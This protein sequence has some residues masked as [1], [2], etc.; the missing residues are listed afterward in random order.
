MK[1]NNLFLL[2]FFLLNFSALA[3]SIKFKWEK[4]DGAILYE[5]EIYP[6]PELTNRL[7]IEQLTKP[8]TKIN[9]GPGQ[10][11]VRVR[12]K[13]A[14]SRWSDYSNLSSV[15]I[16]PKKI[17]EVVVEEKKPKIEVKEIKKEVVKEPEPQ[18]VVIPEE[19]KPREP[20]DI[21]GQFT[22]VYSTFNLTSDSVNRDESLFILML[23]LQKKL[24]TFVLGGDFNFTAVDNGV[25]PNDYALT[26]G[27][28]FFQYFTLKAGAGYYSLTSD[29]N[30]LNSDIKLY[31][32]SL[33]VVYEKE[34]LDR[35]LLRLSPTIKVG[36]PLSNYSA[37]V[38]AHLAYTPTWLSPDSYI[39]FFAGYENWSFESS[40]ETLNT[41]QML[42]GIGFLKQF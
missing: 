25:R 5:I 42:S 30:E 39:D 21:E 41:T 11:Y 12:Y 33:S 32:Y 1:L 28:S 37:Q 20:W 27:K 2:P 13:D 6:G 7:K 4:I 17:P 8:S 34:I 24:G 14:F 35:L 3:E 10:I 29:S 40:T 36:N 23:G 38:R 19:R 22:P 9:S 16:K 26:L 15:T 31:Y 18:V